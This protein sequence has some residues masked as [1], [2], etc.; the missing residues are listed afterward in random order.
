LNIVD[1][2][3]MIRPSVV[4]IDTDRGSGSGVVIKTEANG[5]VYVLTNQHVINLST[6]V[7]VTIRDTEQ[8]DV[9]VVAEDRARDLAVLSFCCDTEAEPV[10]FASDVR[11]GDSV[12]SL[13]Y[14]LGGPGLWASQGIVSVKQYESSA[15][16]HELR[17]NA[18]ITPGDSGGPLV[19]L[20]GTIAGISTYSVRQTLERPLAEG[21]SFA[22]SAETLKAVVPG[23]LAGETITA[24]TPTPQ[25]ET[26]DGVYTNP[27]Y[28]WTINVLHGWTIDD[29]NPGLVAISNNQHEALVFIDRGFV[30]E[31]YQVTGEFT[32]FWTFGSA[33]GWQSFGMLSDGQINRVRATTGQPIQGHEFEYR[34]S[35]DGLDYH[36]FTHWFV[37]E[38]WLDEIVML[39]PGDLWS[40]PRFAAFRTELQN[41]LTSYRP[42]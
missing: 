39:F 9:Q 16:R 32:Y 37:E 4:K 3:E 26:V 7:S 2:V 19:L 10:S 29:S 15:E 23:L 24:P 27:W 18:R 5:E 42:R 14:P 21:F 6:R 28:G 31:Q 22:I 20:D 13:G 33:P 11:I 36:G 38:G 30:G 41:I 25:P 34:F 40:E 12:A 17:T 1:A 8:L 35:I